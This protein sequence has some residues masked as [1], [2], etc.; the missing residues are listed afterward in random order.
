LYW[1]PANIPPHRTLE[2]AA[3]G[4]WAAAA[5][6][7]PLLRMRR[8]PVLELMLCIAWSAAL[9][10]GIEA[11]GLRSPVGELPGAL[12]ATAIVA[13]RP[14]LAIIDETGYAAGIH[15]SVS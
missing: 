10:I 7:Q 14:V 11:V 5:A 3:F 2:L 13:W 6:I 4:V 12:L 8:F 9:V 1:L 15:E